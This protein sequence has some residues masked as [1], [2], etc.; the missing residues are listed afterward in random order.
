MRQIELIRRSD[1]LNQ[2]VW[3]F[4]YDDRRHTL[5]LMAYFRQ[6]RPTLRHKFK[7]SEW[8]DGYNSRERDR[9]GKRI[10]TPPLPDDAKAE[11]VQLF[12]DSLKVVVGFDR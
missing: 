1:N 4:L 7:N 5:A 11:A 3:R 9:I 2:E 12:M 10:D 6:E 8:W